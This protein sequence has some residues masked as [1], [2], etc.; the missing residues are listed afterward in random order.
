MVFVVGGLTTNIL[1]TNEIAYFYVVATTFLWLP[2]SR[3][4]LILELLL[5]CTSTFVAKN[6]LY[7]LILHGNNHK[8]FYKEHSSL[9]IK[10]SPEAV[11]MFWSSGGKAQSLH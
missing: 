11:V 1:P 3:H 6:L 8:L 10:H 7:L 2:I 4:L 5:N 9:F